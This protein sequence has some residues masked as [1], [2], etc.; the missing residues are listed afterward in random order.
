MAAVC[1]M[2]EQPQCPNCGGYK[3]STRARIRG[4]TYT[5]RPMGAR[6]YTL[7]LAA[8]S[9]VLLLLLVE[10]M[11]IFRVNLGLAALVTA[12][13]AGL[14]LWSKGVRSRLFERKY[15]DRVPVNAVYRHHCELCGYEWVWRT[16]T[17]RPEIHVRPQLVMQGA[18]RLW[19]KERRGR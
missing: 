16:G 3:I 13:F 6:M 10:L 4:Y 12:V 11:Y 2:N 7:H 14:I 17:P 9:S 15:L 1:A 5:Q 8:F 18:E 19:G